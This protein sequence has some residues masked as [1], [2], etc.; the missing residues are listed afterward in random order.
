MEEGCS[1]TQKVLCS[2]LSLSVDGF[3]SVVNSRWLLQ[4]PQPHLVIVSARFTPIGSHR[5]T[6]IGSQKLF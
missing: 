5:F 1:R 3:K 4:I 6:L 2:I